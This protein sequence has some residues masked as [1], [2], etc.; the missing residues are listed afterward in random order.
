MKV[1]A[2]TLAFLATAVLLVVAGF[3][4]F[5][6]A[7]DRP[8]GALLARWAP[9][10]SRFLAI[11]G[12]QAHLRDEG[13]R[14]DPQ[15]LVLLHGTSASLH[16]WDGWAA[17]LT[18]AH[19]VIRVDLPGFGLTG[20]DPHGDYTI[21]RYVHFTL[22]LLDALGVEHCVIGGNS[23][24]GWVAWETALARPDRVA[25]LVLIDAAGYEPGSTS[26]PIAFRVA[27]IPLLNELMKVTL[28][29]SLIESSVRN[30]YGDPTRVTPQLV[31]RYYELTLRAGNREG[32]VQRFAQAP[33]GEHAEWIGRIQ[34]PTLILWGGR[35]RLIPPA[36]ARRFES[37]I[38]GSRLV[39]FPEL[40]HVPQEEDPEATVAALQDFLAKP[41]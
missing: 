24:G 39:V 3:V 19:R 1:L 14:D 20:P 12:L 6:W 17:R 34:Q 33:L 23:F 40:G 21:E 36:N 31:D 2:R 26:V 22:A 18:P 16:T 38:H 8:V 10:P 29:R 35:D 5:N 27:R 28:P 4:A 9:P 30:V 25:R 13:P 15:P 7:P 11:D 37:E 32:L 41:Q